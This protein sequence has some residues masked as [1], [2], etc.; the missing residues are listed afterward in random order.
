MNVTKK[1]GLRRVH[2]CMGEL[3]LYFEMVVSF[4]VCQPNH[5]YSHFM[6]SLHSARAIV[7]AG[8]LH[9]YLVRATPPREYLTVLF[10]GLWPQF[11]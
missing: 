2:N 5:S 7:V 11:L 6:F 9:L 4:Y 10:I 1:S 3:A 8:V